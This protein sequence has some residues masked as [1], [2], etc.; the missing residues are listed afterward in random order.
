MSKEGE[1][2]LQ[3]WAGISGSQGIARRGR[4]KRTPP[5]IDSGKGPTT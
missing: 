1:E 5:Y 2:K 4:E 3:G